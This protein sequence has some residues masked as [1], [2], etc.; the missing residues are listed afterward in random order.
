MSGRVHRS[1]DN[2]YRDLGYPNADELR[3]KSVLAARLVVIL[4]QMRLPR[5]E[6]AAVL[7]VSQRK[8]AAILRGDFHETSFAVLVECL[9][10]LG[11]DVDVVLTPAGE[12]GGGPG[13]LTITAA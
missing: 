13:R 8:L 12:P 11:H 3:A 1:S 6:A 10:R 4:D 7:G 5:S 2:I 9:H